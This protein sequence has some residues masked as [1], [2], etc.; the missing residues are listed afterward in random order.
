MGRKILMPIRK[1]VIVGL[2]PALARR[3][4]IMLVPARKL[5]VM[6]ILALARKLV[7][8]GVMLVD[9]SRRRGRSRLGQGPGRGH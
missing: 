2:I 9:L 3:L 7:M 1:L 5:A 6:I 4:V 8:V